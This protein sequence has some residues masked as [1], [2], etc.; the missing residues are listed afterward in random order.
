MNAVAEKF[1][2]STKAECTDHFL[3]LGEKHL[4]YGLRE[5]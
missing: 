3:F 2:Q 1:V 5:W 4:R